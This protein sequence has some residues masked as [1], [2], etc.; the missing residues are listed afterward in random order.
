MS[1]MQVALADGQSKIVGILGVKWN[2]ILIT[3]NTGIQKTLPEAQRTQGIESITRFTLTAGACWVDIVDMVCS[4]WPLKN[5][6][7]YFT[8]LKKLYFLFLYPPISCNQTCFSCHLQYV[9]C[10]WGWF[11]L[12]TQYP[13]SVVPLAMF[14]KLKKWYFLF[15]YPRISGNQNC[16][17][18]YPQN[19]YNFGLTIS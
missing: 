18:F 1:Y 12:W 13:G 7:E 9:I 4:L 10:H 5:A 17:S 2:T 3:R 8:K 6:F 16:I 14:T 19:S 11:E 15:S